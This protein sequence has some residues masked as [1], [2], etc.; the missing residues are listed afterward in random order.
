MVS[1]RN[2][3]QAA[4]IFGLASAMPAPASADIVARQTPVQ[5]NTQEFWL[6]LETVTG[7]TTYNGWI[8]KNSLPPS[9]SP[10]ESS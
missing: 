1:F 4:A 9:L 8:R 2:V 6:T 10:I 5:N 3:A 7:P